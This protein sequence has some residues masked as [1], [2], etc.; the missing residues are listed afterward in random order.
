MNAPDLVTIRRI[1]DEAIQQKQSA[2]I[3]TQGLALLDAMGIGRPHYAIARDADEAASSVDF[4]RFRGDKIVV[5]VISE[6]ILHKSDVGGVAI[7]PNN[8]TA[9]V[10][11]IAAMHKKFARFRVEGYTINEFVTY[12]RQLGGELLFGFRYT[13]DFGPVVT[14]GVGGIYTEY[15][16]SQF[17]P[18]RGVSVI[19]A[20]MATRDII[21]AALGR[22]ATTQILIG[23]LRGQ[24]GRVS[25]DALIDTVERFAKVAADCCPDRIAEFETNPI[26][27]TD[28]GLVAL[29][30]LVKLPSPDSAQKRPAPAP[31]RPLHKLKNL[32]EPSSAAIIGVSEKINPGRIILK[33]LLRDGFDAKRLYVVK[34]QSVEIDGCRCVPAIKDLPE[35][36]D[37]MVLV[38]PAAQV[39]VAI[40]EAIQ[41][42]RAESIIVIPGG[43][44]EKSGTEHI[45]QAMRQ[46]IADS[47]Q[48]EWKGPVINGGN[49]LGIRSRPG[50][51]DTM[52]IPEYKLPL[53]KGDVAPLAVL[54]QSGAF[55]ISRMNKWPHITPKYCATL[56]NQMDLTLGDYLTWLKDDPDLKIF[57][58]YVEGFKPLDGTR[59]VEAAR[60]I[61]RSGRKV[62]LYRA[63]RTAA[64][65][66]ATASHTASIAGDDM[67]T[68]ELCA[69]AG[70]TLAET[71]ADFEDLVKTFVYLQG[72]EATGRRL[73]AVSN[74]GCEC[75]AIADNL[76]H[77]EMARLST[78][79]ETHLKAALKEFKIDEIVDVHNPLDLT[80]MAPDAV[81]E[82][83][84]RRIMNDP[85]VDVGIAGLV[86]LSAML[87]TLAPS[88]AN[89]PAHRENVHDT[90]SLGH[91]FARLQAE[92]TKPWVATVDAGAIYDPLAAILDE[93][94]V[95]V[96]RSA[97]R[98]LRMLRQWCQPPFSEFP[99]HSD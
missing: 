3:E 82:S 76:G 70:I 29:D 25:M 63:G 9:V 1:L 4:T 79:T 66:A 95:P 19:H 89:P 58:V 54:S 88:S 65:A 11:A 73:G 86:P 46:A 80:P 69:A 24:K 14:I 23:G 32:L 35:R 18:A 71:F 7:L 33:N 21:E 43:L 75:V 42:Q 27:V 67:V 98:A 60:E 22:L 40:T 48:S 85:N 28:H 59:F 56:G 31:E 36:V 62:I 91:R 53:P 64:G 34:P 5:K 99:N 41:F 20:K 44:D 45:V 92:I 87:N 13:A 49:C 55:A 97:D 74:A 83:T 47:R 84:F 15:L 94:K 8:K 37:L 93:A 51:Y 78:E 77:F 6:D 30:V 90:N 81:Y 68:R 12:D 16:A 61:I 17:K 50:R 52:F 38:I 10:E 26:V 57:A 2:L 72:R 39:P 96:F